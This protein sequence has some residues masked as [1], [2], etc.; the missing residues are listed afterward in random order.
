MFKGRQLHYQPLSTLLNNGAMQCGSYRFVAC[1]GWSQS[2]VKAAI[3]VAKHS[4][5]CNIARMIASA[6]ANPLD[7]VLGRASEP[8]AADGAP[9]CGGQPGVQAGGGA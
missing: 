5:T 6:G 8:A 4:V 9:H 3:V 1:C 2:T 7:K